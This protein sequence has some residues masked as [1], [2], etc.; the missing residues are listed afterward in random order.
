M[1]TEPNPR[2]RRPTPLRFVL[3]V[4]FCRPGRL[5]AE[6][7]RRPATGMTIAGLGG[8]RYGG[9]ACE[10]AR[11][12]PAGAYTAFLA[13]GITFCTFSTRASFWKGLAM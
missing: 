11:Y 5:Q 4:A 13:S 12:R 1:N 3:F 6:R 2:R 7:L 10:F 9:I 8:L